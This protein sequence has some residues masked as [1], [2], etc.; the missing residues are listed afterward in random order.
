MTV[1]RRP[2]TLAISRKNHGN[3]ADTVRMLNSPKGDNQMASFMYLVVGRCIG[4][5]FSGRRGTTKS[6]FF[7][8]LRWTQLF[9]Y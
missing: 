2:G 8:H 3:S 9:T 1:Q 7:T 4:V 6:S 5:Q